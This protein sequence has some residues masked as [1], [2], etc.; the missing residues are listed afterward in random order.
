MLDQ[1]DRRAELV[2]DVEDE[3]AHVLLL[4]DIHAGHRLVEQQQFRL[5][6]QSARQFDPLLQ[7]IGELPDRHLADRLDLEKVYEALDIGA[8]LELLPLGRPGVNR[9]PEQAAPHPQQASGHDVVEGR[10]AAEQRDILKGAGDALRGGVVRPH[11]PALRALPAQRAALRVIKAVDDIQQRGLAGAVRPDDRED[12]VPPDRQTDPGE[13]LDAAKGKADP[14]GFEDG[15]ADPLLRDHATASAGSAGS[16]V[17]ASRWTGAVITSRIASSA[18][19]VP[20]RPS[21]NVTSLSMRTDSA[22]E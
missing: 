22:P 17:G 10:H 19:I 18:R 3:A 20:L 21:S 11:A 14:I 13:R 12:L 1:R 7:P 6:R 8:V 15:L 5:H 4:L 9:L 16:R 2:V